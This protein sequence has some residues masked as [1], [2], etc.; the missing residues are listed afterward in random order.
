MGL[1]DAGDAGLD[2]ADGQGVGAV[3]E[4]RLGRDAA[5]GRARRPRAAQAG[6][7][8]EALERA[9]AG[10]G[11]GRGAVVRRRGSGDVRRRQPDAEHAAGAERLGGVEEGRVVDHEQLARGPDA[12]AA[13]H[14]EALAVAGLDDRGRLRHVDA[15]HGVDAGV[16]LGHAARGADVELVVREVVGERADRAGDGHAER[17]GDL[18][19]RAGGD[20]AERARLLGEV[21]RDAAL[22]VAAGGDREGGAAVGRRG[23]DPDGRRRAVD[24]GDLLDVV[25]ALEGDVGVAVRTDADRRRAG[26]RTRGRDRVLEREAVRVAVPARPD[27]LRAGRR[28]VGDERELVARPGELGRRI[29]EGGLAGGVGAGAGIGQQA[30]EAGAETAVARALGVLD[31]AEIGV[32]GRRDAAEPGVVVGHPRGAVGRDDRA[33]R[34]VQAVR[35]LGGAGGVGRVGGRRCEAEGE[36]GEGRSTTR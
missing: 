2:R 30:P 6:P 7:A 20:D 16:G 32:R 19:A 25:L 31:V 34:D 35:D 8:Q 9:V 3:G 11:E 29:E 23:D 17:P 22:R 24:V 28:A 13:D 27:D 18:R 26:A 1:G 33:R 14:G 15:M 10:D 12:E 5:A 36:R 21:E 4:V